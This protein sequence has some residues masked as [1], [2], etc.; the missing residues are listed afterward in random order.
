LIRAPLLTF[1]CPKTKRRAPTRVRADVQTLRD[2][3]KSTL[4]V[5]CR[6]GEVHDISVRDAYLNANLDVQEGP[7][8]QPVQGG[9]R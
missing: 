4:H 6:C 2:S 3:L 9:A 1:M 8:R 5:K 7:V